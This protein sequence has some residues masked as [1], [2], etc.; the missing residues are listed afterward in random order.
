VN[1][2][3]QLIITILSKLKFLDSQNA[4][5][6]EVLIIWVFLFITAFR[7]LF[8]GLTL[9]IPHF[10]IKWTI[11]DIN[12]SNVLPILFGLLAQSHKLYLD[13]K[14]F[15]GKDNTNVNTENNTGS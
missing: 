11:L 3:K 5:N 9:T 13:S 8:A 15:N 10:G 7:A 4:L 12:V 1:N 6:L 14:N 2:I